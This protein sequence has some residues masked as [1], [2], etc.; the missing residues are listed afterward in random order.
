MPH[1]IQAVHVQLHA[2]VKE[3]M[4][5]K[6]SLQMPQL[7]SSHNTSQGVGGRGPD[8]FAPAAGASKG[9]Q[10]P[11]CHSSISHSGSQGEWPGMLAAGTSCSVSPFCWFCWP[12]SIF[13]QQRMYSSISNNAMDGLLSSWCLHLRASH[14]P[15]C[16]QLCC[17]VLHACLYC[18]HSQAQ[19]SYSMIHLGLHCMIITNPLTAVACIHRGPALA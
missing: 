8:K 9:G 5:S 19:E 16:Y 15:H 1:L 12:S 11:H 18:G 10:Q 3:C 13:R 7:A 14:H 6:S 4:G 17:D 2:L